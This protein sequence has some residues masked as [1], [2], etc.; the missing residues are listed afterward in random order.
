MLLALLSGAA[1]LP[2]DLHQEGL[3]HLGDWLLE[4]EIT[5]YTCVA[6]IFRHSVENLNRKEKFPKIRLI[7]VGGELV[8]KTDIELYKNHFQM[9][10]YSLI[11]IA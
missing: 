10:A 4:E 9:I 3:A 1:F 11:G 2:F 5:V 7:H 8:S 6:T